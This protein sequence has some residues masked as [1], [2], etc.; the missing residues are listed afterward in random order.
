M[1]K[2]IQDPMVTGKGTMRKINLTTKAEINTTKDTI[3]KTINASSIPATKE[4]KNKLRQEK[5]KTFWK[6]AST[7]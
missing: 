4:N 3:I 7:V 1:T 2:S 6:V 5:R